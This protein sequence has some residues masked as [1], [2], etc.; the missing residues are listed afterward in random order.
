MSTQTATK[1]ETK[2]R[3]NLGP[4]ARRA[5]RAVARFVNPPVLAIAGKRYMPIVG[6]VHHLGAKTGRK[7]STPLGVRRLG[8]GFVMPL[9]FSESAH[10]YRNT[11]AAG[12]CVVTYRGEDHDAVAPE[13]IGALGAR[14]FPRYEQLLFRIIGINEY[15]WVHQRSL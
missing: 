9:T 3:I 14:A 12:G 2:N 10:W 7:Y 1:I 15:L 11:L 13:V 4:G 8:D 6:V 5:V